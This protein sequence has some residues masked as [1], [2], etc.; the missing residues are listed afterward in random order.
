L[1]HRLVGAVKLKPMVAFD[2][3]ET[4]VRAAEAAAYA[5]Q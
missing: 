2:L 5:P 3:A 4:R 1:I